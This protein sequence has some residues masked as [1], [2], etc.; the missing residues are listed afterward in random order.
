MNSFSNLTIT[1]SE[2]AVRSIAG[3]R[4][5]PLGRCASTGTFAVNVSRMS[6]SDASAGPF[7]VDASPISAL[8][9]SFDAAA[10]TRIN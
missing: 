3:R 5:A 8:S 9:E 10:E 4:G 7:V 1:S 6:S 2:Y